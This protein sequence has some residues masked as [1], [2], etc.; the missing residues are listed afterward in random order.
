AL[1]TRP[2]SVPRPRPRA[3]PDTPGPSADGSGDVPASPR[4]DVAPRP[5]LRSVDLEYLGDV[6][7]PRRSTVPPPLPERAR[8]RARATAA[9]RMSH[10]EMADAVL[11]AL[12]D[13]VFFETPVEAVAFGVVTAM[14]VLPSLGGLAM[15]RDED[16]GYVTVYARGPHAYEVVRSRVSEDDPIVELALVRGGPV[17]VEYGSDT[18]PPARHAT[19]GDPWSALVTPIVVDD[20]CVGALE[21]VDPLDGRTLGD[22]AR[23]AL[24][25]IAQHLALFLRGR[26]ANVRAAYAPEQVGLEG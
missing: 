14:Q 24:T 15:L 2:I 25:T 8:E 10:P 26:T 20:R 9:P 12:R 4:S 16:G 7:P 3:V 21:L 6:E 19:F 11:T 23:H 22:S 13:L 1:V 18:P 17:A 5:T